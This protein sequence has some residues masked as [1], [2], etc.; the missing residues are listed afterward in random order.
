MGHVLGRIATLPGRVWRQVR[1]SPV[2]ACYLAVVWV[3]GLATGSIAQ[4]PPRWLSGRVGAGLPSLGH[5]YWWTPLSAGLWAAGLSGY[6]V[7]TALGGLILAPA[8]RRLGVVRT[9]ATLLASQAIGL[10]LA[11][12]LIELGELLHEPWLR[13]MADETAVG[14]LPGLLGVGYALSCTLT[15]L[16]RRRLRLLITAAVTIGV[17]YLGHLE[18]VAEASGA[19]VGLA[20]ATL[21]CD[22]ACPRAGQRRSNHE[23]RVLVG[24]LVAAPAIGGVLA[25]L[26]A[27][28]DG[29]MTLSSPCAGPAPLPSNLAVICRPPGLTV[30]CRG[31]REQQLYAHWSSIPVQAAPAL[32]LL[33][34]AYGLRRG[35]RLA[36]WLAIVSNVTELAAAIRLAYAAGS[37]LGGQ[38]PREAMIVP[39]VT[40]TVLLVTR[41]RFDQVA[42]RQAAGKLTAIVAAALG[43]SGGVLLLLGSLL[44]DRTGARSQVD[45][46]VSELSA[47]FLPG[48]LFDG[49]LPPQDLA[50]RLLFSWVFLL[51]WTVV[52][53]ALTASFLRT[54]AF[55]DAAEPDQVR[56]ILA[57]GGSTLSY[58]STWP[59]NKY[60]ISSDG[61]SAIAYRAIGTIAVTVGDPFGEQAELESVIAEFAGFC[62]D[63]G[64]RACLYSATGQ[65][66]AAAQRL[67]WTSV[68]IAEDTLLPLERLQFTGK[69][70]QGVRAAMNK[71]AKEGITAQWWSFRDMPP[72]IAG[73]I[74]Q[75]SGSWVADK[76]LPEMGFM[77][78]GLAEL[79][80]PDVRCLVA[81]GADRT[82]HGITSWMPVYADGRPVGW[83]IDFMRRS[84]AASTCRGVMEFLI[85][86]AALAFREEG[87][88]FVS[89]SA[90]P[91]ARLDRS[92]QPCAIQGLLDIIGTAIEPVYGFRSLL[93]F[94]A[95]FQPE[96]E[97]LYL[98]YPDPAALG[99][100]VI[101]IGRA[102]LPSLT[103][104]QALRLL[105]KLR[106]SPGTAAPAG[107]LNPGP[108]GDLAA[109]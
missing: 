93:R 7:M 60:W 37:R 94:K 20:G 44:R 67:G 95:K 36:W 75:I 23:V 74:R 49:R 25:A 6:L 1:R 46:V 90:A 96:Y 77:L 50:G 68:Q 101:A 19:A 82:V 10:L 55:P 33:L 13:S 29:P 42:D 76:G 40:L 2:T 61:R 98:I 109:L 9:F 8:E 28:A 53:G 35:R 104:R 56:A 105:A 86:T 65:S 52:L 32:L 31:L 66:R 83:T 18:Q 85:A 21:T 27:N 81:V 39:V 89:L 64:L 51:F 108:V 3:V 97:P 84:P 24:L 12:G 80:D 103:S 57:R 30:V 72:D 17:M 45:G 48:R 22:L 14:A 91:L 87:A 11:A 106:W 99:P 43:A 4:G 38:L 58:M 78:G 62:E 71:A 70:W 47:L 79:C 54:C 26:I 100:I 5:G 16:W 107:Q 92:E 41:R 34:S 102:Y 69:K 59:G 63:R 15:L 73:Q 88:R